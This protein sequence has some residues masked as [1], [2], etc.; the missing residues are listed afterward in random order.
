MELPGT[1]Q[2][3][4]G[5]SPRSSFRMI[6]VSPKAAT[7]RRAVAYGELMA[8]AGTI[9]IVAERR[10]PKGDALALAEV[11]GI[12][13]AKTVSSA[14]PLCHPLPLDSVRIRCE[15][16]G[17]RIRV[18]CEAS[19]F[20]KTGVEMEALAGTSAALLC[21]HD[22]IKGIDPGLEIG[23]VRVLVKE[24]GKTGVWKHPKGDPRAPSSEPGPESES[25][26]YLLDGVRASVITASDRCSRGDTE[27]VS[28]PAVRDWLA[29]RGA[30]LVSTETVP[31]EP[32]VLRAA[33]SDALGDGR[34][35]LVVVTGGTGLGPRDGSPEAV[36]ALGGREI[37]GFGEKMRAQGALRAKHAWLS[38]STGHVVRGAVVL[39]VPGSPKGAVESLD[40][41]RELLAHAI[42]IA[43]GGDHKF[44]RPGPAR[45]P[46]RIHWS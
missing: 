4:A 24:G 2:Q 10:L 1:S 32:A 3:S 46:A 17:D 28:G 7:Q 39:A 45:L 16:L 19:A 20:A 40:A 41:V 42:D 9:R 35:R 8:D 23:G 31:D 21:L 12:Q 6:D 33:L 30:E 29:A 37:P 18:T 34:A 38:R 15:P 43:G 22:L 13:G 5:E 14:L 27:D 26:R 25:D 44:L 11:A 36:S